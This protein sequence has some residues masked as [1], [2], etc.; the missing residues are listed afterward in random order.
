MFVYANL[1]TPSGTLL[2][3][4]KKK[5]YN[6]KYWLKMKSDKKTTNKW[7]KEKWMNTEQI[8]VAM[9]NLKMN[10]C[11]SA[12]RKLI[13]PQW[14]FP[15]LMWL[16]LKSSSSSRTTHQVPSSHDT[17]RDSTGRFSH[18]TYENWRKDSNICCILDR[19][20]MPSRYPKKCNAHSYLP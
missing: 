6:N 16:Y 20:E 8:R 15:P 18:K 9:W 17:P 3:Q 5:R 7:I 13:P 1:Y 19:S 11:D 12:N 2:L 10:C 14:Q 4:V